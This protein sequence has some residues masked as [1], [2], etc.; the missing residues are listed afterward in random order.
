[1]QISD[2]VV[3]LTRYFC[4]ERK[5]MFF[6]CQCDQG[7]SKAILLYQNL[8]RTPSPH[9]TLSKTFKETPCVTTGD[10][11]QSIGSQRVRHDLETEEQHHN[12][13]QSIIRNQIKQ[14]QHCNIF[15]ENK[16]NKPRLLIS[17]GIS[18]S[19]QHQ[20][21]CSTLTLVLQSCLPLTTAQKDS[22]L[23][24]SPVIRLGPPEKSR[25][26]SISRSLILII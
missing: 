1:M 4:G 8:N 19:F 13:R 15:L 18:S 12:S 14:I 25:I 5:G 24:R 26:T 3:I 16:A 11:L 17:K 21:H 6:W 10:M 20:Q 22:L 23:L 7:T 9:W 2:D